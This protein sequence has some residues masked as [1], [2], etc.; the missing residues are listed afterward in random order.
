MDSVNQWLSGNAQ[1]EDT[2]PLYR[3]I[4]GRTYVAV[5]VVIGF[6]QMEIYMYT[7]MTLP[8]QVM[9]YRHDDG[10]SLATRELVEARRNRN[11]SEPLA[12]IPMPCLFGVPSQLPPDPKPDQNQIHIEICP[13]RHR[14]QTRKYTQTNQPT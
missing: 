4:V 5:W 1:F 9:E 10:N 13:A 6:S 12:L 14:F 7:Y 3:W 11:L 2:S 8:Q